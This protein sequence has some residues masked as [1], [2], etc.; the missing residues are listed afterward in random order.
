MHDIYKGVFIQ[1]DDD[2]DDD[3]AAYERN[4]PSRPFK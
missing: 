1:L 4:E 3:C 2:D